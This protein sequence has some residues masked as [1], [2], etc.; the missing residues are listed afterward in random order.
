MREA[1]RP[2]ICPKMLSEAKLS[3]PCGRRAPGHVEGLGGVA[4]VAAG[5]EVGE[6][7]EV[8]DHLPGEVGDA[9]SEPE[10]AETA[11]TISSR[12]RRRR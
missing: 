1:R 4:L 5:L 3:K 8:G 9:R 12:L 10:V 6:P 7:V 11:R 2:V